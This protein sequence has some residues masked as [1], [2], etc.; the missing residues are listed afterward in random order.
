ME[1]GRKRNRKKVVRKIERGSNIYRKKG[2][3]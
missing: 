3:G 1:K 2:G